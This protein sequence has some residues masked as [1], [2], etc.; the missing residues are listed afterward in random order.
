MNEN[1]PSY[2]RM[3]DNSVYYNGDGE[4][5]F[6]VPEIF[7]SRKHA[8]IEGD[9]IYLIGV[10]SYCKNVKKPEDLSKNVK[11]FF[12]PSAFGTKPNR[13]E[14]V[15]NFKVSE[16]ARADDY[17]ILYYGNNNEDQIITSVEIP[18]ELSNVEEFFSIFVNTGK[19]PP[20]IPIDK[21][22]DYFSESM[23]LNGGSFGLSQQSFGLLVS[24]LCRD[25]NDLS[26]PFRL[27]KMLD[28]DKTA[29]VP[30]SIKAIAKLISPFTSVVTENWDEA[31]VNASIIDSDKAIDAPMEP[32]MTGDIK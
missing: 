23:A 32:I 12:Y 26:K 18:E 4:F 30:V 25:P 8:I 27:S 29:Y 19:I 21:L 7:F 16:T 1:L 13:T 11:R 28:K 3:K 9:T 5:A 20:G 15:K 22:D 6:I 10:I 17:R 14:K 24:E 2:L 31:V